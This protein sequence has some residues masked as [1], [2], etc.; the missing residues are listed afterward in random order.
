MSILTFGLG[1][2]G[3]GTSVFGKEVE[4]N[5]DSVPDIDV[6]I[7]DVVTVDVEIV[8]EA[9]V[10]LVNVI[11]VDVETQELNVDKSCP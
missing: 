3:E 4:V 9:E 2:A 8:E 10:E 1:I 7:A 11:E 6:E 5:I